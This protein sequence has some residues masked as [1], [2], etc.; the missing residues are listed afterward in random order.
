MSHSQESL[1]HFI[2]D[3]RAEERRLRKFSPNEELLWNLAEESPFEQTRI[4]TTNEK[5]LAD[6]YL[7]R[8]YLTPERELLEA[9]LYDLGVPGFLARQMRYMPRPYLHYFFRG[10]D[11]RAF[12]NHPWKRSLSVILIGGYIEHTWDFQLE[13]SFSRLLMPGQVNL[14]KRG[15]YHRVELLPGEKCWTL[16]TSMGRVQESDGQDWDFYDPE[17]G[18]Y[19]PWGKWTAENSRRRDF[20]SH[21]KVRNFTDLDRGSVLGRALPAEPGSY[22]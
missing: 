11:D 21:A 7:M 8:V 22:D 5:V 1:R 15:T 12:H 13:R 4:I 20:R 3:C 6:P 10:D 9:R 17:T 2:T 18:E 19:T 14:L 16:F